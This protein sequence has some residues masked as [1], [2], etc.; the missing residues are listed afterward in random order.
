MSFCYFIDFIEFHWLIV[1]CDPL[2]AVWVCS[3][4]DELKSFPM[5][6]ATV[7]L[8][9]MLLSLLTMSDWLVTLLR[10]S[11]PP[12]LRTQSLMPSV[13]LVVTGLTPLSSMMSSSSPSRY[14]Q[15]K[16]SPLKLFSTI[17]FYCFCF[18]AGGWEEC[19]A[20]HWSWDFSGKEGFCP[21]GDFSHGFGQDEG[22]CWSI[23]WK[24]GDSCCC[25]CPCLL[26]RRSAPGY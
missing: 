4:M 26:Q 3:R 19:Q 9:L 13:S 2:F 16:I 10:T 24:E 5:T 17:W 15:W 8:H 23:S 6:K 11:L 21:W 12:T 1:L 14:N 20:L 7:L 18:M 22:S 25:H